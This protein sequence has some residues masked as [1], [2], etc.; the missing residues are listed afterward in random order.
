[1]E[2]KKYAVGYIRVSTEEQADDDRYGIDVQKSKILMYADANGYV[3]AKWYTDKISGAS[4]DRPE[5]NKILSGD[6]ITNPPYEAVIAFKSDRI[7]RDMKLYFYYLFVLEKRNIKMIST[8]EEFEGE[9]ANIYRA[10]MMFVAEQERK[11]IALRTGSGRKAKAAAGGYS[12]GRCPYGYTVTEGNLIVNPEEAEMIKIIFA[13]RTEGETLQGIA[14]H[15]N[16]LGYRTRKGHL[17]MFSDIRNILNNERLYRGEYSYGN[18]DENG[19][20]IYVPGVQE[21]ILK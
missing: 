10:L 2:A 11:N 13:K 8:Q 5:W 19:N 15:I 21:P 12:G 18:K 16:N 9:F 1:M 20:K 14:E 17:F 4:G 6:D 7:A 3:I